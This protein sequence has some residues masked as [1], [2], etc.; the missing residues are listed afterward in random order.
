MQTQAVSP[1]RT[2]YQVDATLIATRRFALQRRGLVE[3]GCLWIRAASG[4]LPCLRSRL[5]QE[6]RFRQ[7][8]LHPAR[9][10]SAATCAQ[11]AVGSAQRQDPS[12]PLRASA[13]WDAQS[14]EG[15]PSVPG[16]V[17]S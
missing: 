11:A 6:A 15:L 10:P 3:W 7:L 8:G 12:P 4:R 16:G 5:A 17:G 13:P 1:G 14:L 2:S 9:P